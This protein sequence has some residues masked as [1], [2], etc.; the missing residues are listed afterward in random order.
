MQSFMHFVLSHPQVYSKVLAEI[1]AASS[2][3]Q[4]GAM[5]SFQDATQHLPYFQAALKEAMRLRPAV[6]LNIAR[7][8]PK[9]GADIDGQWYAGGVECAVNGW[10]LHRDRKVFGDDAELYRP[11]RWLEED[12]ERVKAMDRCMFQ[13]GFTISLAHIVVD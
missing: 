3:G 10:V 6:G 4:L 2:T 12:K 8:V 7:H 5:V 13:V 1:D 9:G 11:E